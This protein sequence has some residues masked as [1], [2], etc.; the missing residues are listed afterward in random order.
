MKRF[1]ILIVLLLTSLFA[2]AQPGGP[3]PI[4]TVKLW[5]DGAPNAFTIPGPDSGFIVFRAHEYEEEFLEVY[6]AKNP[7][8]LCVIMCPGGAYIM[9]S[10]RQ[11]ISIRAVDTV[12]DGRIL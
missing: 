6:P 2:F 4:D 10:Q 12:S 8:G 1:C 9:E 7:N 5:P 3:A 11:C